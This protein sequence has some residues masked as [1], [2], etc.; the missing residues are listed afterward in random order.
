MIH[1]LSPLFFSRRSAELRSRRDTEP[2][3]INWYIILVANDWTDTEDLQAGWITYGGTT[4]YFIPCPT[5]F[6]VKK[7]LKNNIVPYPA[8]LEYL[9][10]WK[11]SSSK[12]RTLL[13]IK[14][15]FFSF[16][17]PSGL[18]SK[19]DLNLG[20][21]RPSTRNDPAGTPFLIRSCRFAICNKSLLLLPFQFLDQSFVWLIDCPLSVF[22]QCQVS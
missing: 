10:S 18:T 19:K 7:Y 14:Y 6:L 21:K 2:A 1:H 4:I 13:A 20:L 17:A 3:I 11:S 9:P 5:L 15:S 22:G 16:P 12:W 8:F